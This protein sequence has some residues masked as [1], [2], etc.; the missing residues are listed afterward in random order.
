[1][2]A[3]NDNVSNNSTKNNTPAGS[4]TTYQTTLP[5]APAQPNNQAPATSST[6]QAAPNAANSTQAVAAPTTNTAPLPSQTAPAARVQFAASLGTGNTIQ[7][8]GAAQAT[9]LDQLGLPIGAGATNVVPGNDAGTGTDQSAATTTGAVTN[10]FALPATTVA[11]NQA[12]ASATNS[13]MQQLASLGIATANQVGPIIPAQK[14]LDTPVGAAASK[15]PSTSAPA[16][17]ANDASALATTDKSGASVIGA[18]AN[19]GSSGNPTPPGAA[20]LN[21]RVVAGAN[22]LTGQPNAASANAVDPLLQAREQNNSSA[23]NP[24]VVAASIE[25]NQSTTPRL[26]NAVDLAS[27]TNANAVPNGATGDFRNFAA[28]LNHSAAAARDAAPDLDAD[29]VKPVVP[30]NSD[31]NTPS[32]NTAPSPAD[33]TIQPNTAASAPADASPRQGL[34]LVPASEQVAFHLKQALKNGSDEIQIQL[35][36]AS[37]GAIDVKLNVAHDGRLTAVISA[38]RSDT[39]NLLKQDQG[40]LQQSLRDA[41]FNADSSSLSFS[42]RG[43]AQ[44]F[45][46]NGSQQN[47][48]SRSGSALADDSGLPVAA[49][50]LRQ[51]SGS[52]DIQA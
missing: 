48:A 40:N 15:Q 26:P 49:R 37:L 34:I 19:A 17:A 14:Q 43:D 1:V 32:S 38:D 35:K 39:L 12:A 5:P 20:E 44:S 33:T 46:Q 8:G 30:A 42:L 13:S 9:A 25:K 27:S 23:L 2:T 10:Q 16:I 18:N 31:A 6:S 21:A 11:Q 47:N 50:A 22:K 52:I 24:L 28:A 7:L 45:A 4:S 51:H 36:P 41:G 3:K 29:D